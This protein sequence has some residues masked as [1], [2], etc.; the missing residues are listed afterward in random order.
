MKDTSLPQSAAPGWRRWALPAGL[1]L[2]LAVAVSVQALPQK[3]EALLKPKLA[4]AEYF[5]MDS[6]GWQGH[7]EPLAETEALAGTVQTILNYD[8]AMLRFY[9]KGGQQFSVYVA[10]WTPGKMPAR[11]IA[12]HIPDKC[13]TATGMT[14]T[15]A[16][17]NY[18]KEFD[19]Q[20]LAPA[21]YR[22]FESPGVKQAVIYWHIYDGKTIVYN[23]DGSPSDLSMVTDLMKRGLKQRGEQFFIRIATP[24]QLEPL[25][26]D[27]GFRDIIELIAP[28]GPGLTSAI[29]KM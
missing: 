28:L 5:P 1:T 19:G 24:G 17:Y 4:L 23:P 22:E 26:N 2:L 13:W 29:Q 7:D 9:K 21:Q 12:F 11:D 15:A 8:D 27:Q 20:P 10:Y 14:R 6:G 3:Q 18:Q 16:N 25:W